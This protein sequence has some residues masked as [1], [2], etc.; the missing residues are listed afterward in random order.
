MHCTAG[1]L[2]LLCYTWET[3]IAIQVTVPAIKV[4]RIKPKGTCIFWQ[5]NFDSAHPTRIMISA[6]HAQPE[7]VYSSCCHFCWNLWKAKA[8]APKLQSPKYLK[9]SASLIWLSKA[10]NHFEPH[11]SKANEQTNSAVLAKIICCMQECKYVSQVLCCVSIK[12]CISWMAEP[13]S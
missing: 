13:K 3:K 8:G 5:R 6:C 1:T 10:C 12:L 2:S 9:S 4:R 7:Q 11:P